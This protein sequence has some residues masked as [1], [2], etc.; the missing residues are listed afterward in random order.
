M[1][2]ND[3]RHLWVKGYQGSILDF[4]D[5][6]DLEREEFSEWISSRLES[7]RCCNAVRTWLSEYRLANPLDTNPLDCVPKCGT[8][9]IYGHDLDLHVAAK[10]DSLKL[11]VFV[12]GQQIRHIEFM[13]MMW[14]R[15]EAGVL[16]ACFQNSDRPFIRCDSDWYVSVIL[17]EI[18]RQEKC[19][20]KRMHKKSKQLARCKNNQDCTTDSPKREPVS[21][22][23]EKYL[24]PQRKPKTTKQEHTYQNCVF[25]IATLNFI[26]PDHVKFLIVTDYKPFDETI[27][28]LVS[29]KRDAVLVSQLD[30][31]LHCLWSSRELGIECS[32]YTKLIVK[33]LELEDRDK[34]RDLLTNLYSLT[35]DLILKNFLSELLISV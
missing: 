6:R 1:D 9:T 16:V 28:N 34:H 11:I 35:A 4:I 3:L 21:V 27:S 31:G 33:M 13:K 23:K 20:E 10:S 25:S 5:E 18:F 26:L 14:S 32:E 19:E 12:C 15:Q 24:A 2:S 17:S 29:R 8:H 22:Q 30:I 7:A